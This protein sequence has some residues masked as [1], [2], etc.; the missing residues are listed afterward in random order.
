MLISS[1]FWLLL[2]KTPAFEQSYTLQG[3]MLLVFNIHFKKDY[4]NMRLKYVY[5]FLKRKQNILDPPT[6][7]LHWMYVHYLYLSPFKAVFCP[8]LV[9]VSLPLSQVRG[10]G[11][12]NFN[13][14][15]A[16][17]SLGVGQGNSLVRNRSFDRW[18]QN[19]PEKN[20]FT[21]YR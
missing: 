15:L 9:L 2:Q 4:V 7:R 14:L 10:I 21:V 8:T 20:R 3:Y 19:S 16:G 18:T 1:K 13:V 12:R 6:Q 17:I 11:L 5:R